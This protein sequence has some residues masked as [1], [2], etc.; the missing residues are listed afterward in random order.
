MSSQQKAGALIPP[1]MDRCQAEQRHGSFMTLG[2]RPMVRCDSQPD[3]IAVEVVAGADGQY[4]S[5]SLCLSCA[6]AM[7][8][9]A[10]LRK[11]VQLQPIER[12]PRHDQ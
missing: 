12:E 2:P 3:F 5:M 9:D 1:D 8:E 6:K 7:L 10:D 11:R 4:G